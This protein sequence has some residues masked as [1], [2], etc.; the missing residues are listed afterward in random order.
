MTHSQA[1]GPQSAHGSHIPARIAGG[2]RVLLVACQ[3]SSSL[4][5]RL[6]KPRKLVSVKTPATEPVIVNQVFLTP[7]RASVLLGEP[8]G[9]DKRGGPRC[10]VS[11]W[12]LLAWAGSSWWSGC[13][14]VRTRLRRALHR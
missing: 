5:E 4:T 10:A 7:Q 12:R 2:A 14:A 8:F 3:L 9:L 1:I 11:Q 13:W 6:G